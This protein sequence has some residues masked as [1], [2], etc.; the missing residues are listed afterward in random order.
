MAELQKEL[1]AQQKLLDQLREKGN[2]Y[3]AV[4]DG[5]VNTVSG[6]HGNDGEDNQSVLTVY[7]NVCRKAS[8]DDS[9]P[10]NV[11]VTRKQGLKRGS[12]SSEGDH[13]NTSDE[14]DN[15]RVGTNFISKVFFTEK[16]M[17]E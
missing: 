14:T 15:A 1:E 7:Q 16:E 12:S 4:G 17:E 2:L 10:E 8:D 3:P 11:F 5:K 9:S 6:N 13:L